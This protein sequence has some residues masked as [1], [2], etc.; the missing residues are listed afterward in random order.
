MKC[1]AA[2]TAYAV[3]AAPL[4]KKVIPLTYKSKEVHMNPSYIKF[5]LMKT[6]NS[7]QCDPSPYVKNA[8]RDFTRKRKISFSDLI[9]SIISME[10]HTL[11]RELRRF[12]PSDNNR[13]PTKSAYIQQRKKLNDNAFPH[14]FSVLNTIFPFR[15]KFHGLHLLACDGSDVNIPPCPGDA[16]TYVPSNTAGVGYHQMHLNALYDLIE[17]RY[18]DVVI[19]KRAEINERAAFI[20][21]VERNSL[22]GKCLYVADRGYFSLNVL[23]H[24]IYAEQFFLL[25]LNDLN[26]SNSFIK[27][28]PLPSSREFDQ[29]VSF[30]VTRK[31]SNLYKN[32]PDRFFVVRKSRPFDLIP[33]DDKTTLF[34][35]S[36]RIIKIELDGG[37]TEYLLTN[38]PECQFGIALIKDIYHMRWGIE[39]SFRYLKYNVALNYFHSCLR[40]LIIQEFFA[41]LILYNMTMLLI[42]CVKVVQSGRKYKRKVS[43]SDA[44]VTCRY[45]LIQRIKNTE[46]RNQLLRYLTDIRPGRIY[47]RKV[48]SKRFESLTNRT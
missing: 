16:E 35:M 26:A 17:E 7:M 38:L 18:P 11:N 25:R 13:T 6:I 19:Q 41:R 47:P 29:R 22:A 9:L 39:T 5:S 46:I 33:E 40:E 42:G 31:K 3:N 20:Q 12:F 4:I 23:A 30:E 2:L 21:M 43:V 1:A 27:R 37:N 15:K 32:H 24:V 8:G 48:R 14:I 45:F 10:N 36:I 44:V 34:P 28:F